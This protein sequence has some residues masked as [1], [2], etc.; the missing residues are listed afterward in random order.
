MLSLLPQIPPLVPLS[1]SQKFLQKFLPVPCLTLYQ[2][3]GEGLQE[4]EGGLKAMLLQPQ[5]TRL[6]G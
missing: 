1:K 4:G 3:E 2:G 5:P 6:H